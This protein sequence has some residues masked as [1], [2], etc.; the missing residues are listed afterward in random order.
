MVF[1]VAGLRW[2]CSARLAMNVT[3]VTY[4]IAPDPLAYTELHF[5]IF[6]VVKRTLL[7]QY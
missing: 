5:L 2:P 3:A 4:T 1:M 7:L 6:V